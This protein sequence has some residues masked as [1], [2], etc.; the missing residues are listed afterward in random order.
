MSTVRLDISLG[1]PPPKKR[2]KVADTDSRLETIMARNYAETIGDGDEEDPWR[3]G[4]LK[5]MKNIGMVARG[6]F[7]D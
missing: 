4:V 1:R 3:S 7:T 5:Y 6:V 2:R